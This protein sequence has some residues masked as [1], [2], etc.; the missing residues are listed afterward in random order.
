VK[1]Y[2][3]DAIFYLLATILG[4]TNSDFSNSSDNENN[5]EFEIESINL[6]MQCTVS[7][8][9]VDLTSFERGG[10]GFCA[11]S[12]PKNTCPENGHKL[13]LYEI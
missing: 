3:D 2:K 1:T 10:V 9:Q 4:Y 7:E 6:Q 12:E 5:S 8:A 11:T 13:F